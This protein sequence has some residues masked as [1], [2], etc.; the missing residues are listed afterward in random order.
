MIKSNNISN[1]HTQTIS[2]LL[3]NFVALIFHWQINGKHNVIE[4]KN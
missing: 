1:P 2:K 3:A 4:K